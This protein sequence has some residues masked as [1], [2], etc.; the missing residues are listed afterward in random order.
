[1]NTAIV[2]AGGDP[3]PARVKQLLPAG[4]F[5]IAADSGYD[6]ARELG[7]PVALV[8]G[9]LDSLSPEGLLAARQTQ[10]EQHPT[11]KD[12]SDLTLALRTAARRGAQRVL[13]VGGSGGR[14]DHFLANAA[15]LTSNEFAALQIEWLIGPAV[16]SVVRSEAEI[17]GKQGDMIT[18]LAQG[19]D[20]AGVTTDGLRWPLSDETITYG[21]S[22]GLSNQLIADRAGVAIKSGVLLVIHLPAWVHEAGT[23]SVTQ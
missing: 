22:R 11:D 2:F 9:D 15:V 6:H 5:V 21:S 4:A 17:H 20:A 8:V 23:G 12:A 18:L 19:G 1:M 14:I 10:I 3:P 13:V 16:V 7:V